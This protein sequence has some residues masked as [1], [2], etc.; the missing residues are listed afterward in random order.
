MNSREDSKTQATAVVGNDHQAA[1]GKCLICAAIPYFAWGFIIVG[2][3][4]GALSRIGVALPPFV[5]AGSAYLL[6]L[7]LLGLFVDFLNMRSKKAPIF[8]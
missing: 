3:I 1:A 5:E 4:I 6:A 2:G 8:G 7:G